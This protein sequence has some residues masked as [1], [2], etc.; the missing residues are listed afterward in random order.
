MNSSS[1]NLLVAVKDGT[2]FVKVRGRATFVCSADFRTL[3]YQLR[4]RGCRRYVLD[5]TECIILDSTFLGMLAGFGLKLSDGANDRGTIRLLNPNARIIDLLDNLGVVH[6]F[7]LEPEAT[8]LVID[9]GEGKE[10]VPQ[11]DRGELAKTSLEAHETLMALNPE[12]A[13]KF[14]DV[15]R[16]L[17]EDL[18]KKDG[19]QV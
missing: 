5:L 15:A 13:A 2:A 7:Q 18:K 19:A 12:N 10:V 6:L 1:S 16:F 17:K 11:A 4:D 14:K 9:D 3:V 8:P